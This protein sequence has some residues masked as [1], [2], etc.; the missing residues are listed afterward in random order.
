MFT[1][2]SGS[3]ILPRLGS[4]R[5]RGVTIYGF[6]KERSKRLRQIADQKGLSPTS[7]G[8]LRFPSSSGSY[9]PGIPFVNA[10]GETAPAYAV[11]KITDHFAATSTAPFMLE[12]GKPDTDFMALYLVNGPDPIANNAVGPAGFFYT[13]DGPEQYALYNTAATP[14]GGESWSPKPASWLLHKNGPGF[15]I[16]GG[17]DGTK[18][19]VLQYIPQEIFIKNTGASR[20][21]NT[22]PHEY[23]VWIGT[24]GSESDSGFRVQAYN[25]MSVSFGSG[26]FGFAAIVNGQ[27][28]AIRM[29]V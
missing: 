23:E 4:A 27:G 24:A 17:P 11:M 18:V 12:I 9:L 1:H 16:L 19:N 20:S 28:Y 2:R 15:A 7:V 25:R 22:G 5:G 8:G 26:K 13:G 14:L 29:Q 21:A 10:S 3:F 6:N